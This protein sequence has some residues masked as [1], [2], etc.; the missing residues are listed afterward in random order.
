MGGQELVEDLQRE[1]SYLPLCVCVCV[2]VYVCVCVVCGV[3]CGVC[4]CVCVC[5]SVCVCVHVCMCMS[6]YPALPNGIFWPYPAILGYITR[7]IL[8]NP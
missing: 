2:C 4:V 1:C 8:D 3:V 6:E 5:D 7:E